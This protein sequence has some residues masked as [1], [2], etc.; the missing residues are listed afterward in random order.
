MRARGKRSAAPGSI[1]KRARVLKGRQT[2]V[3]PLSGR[4][5]FNQA[6][7]GL[8]FACPWLISGIPSG[9]WVITLGGLVM[10]RR[11]ALLS[12]LLALSIARAQTPTQTPPPQTPPSQ[13]PPSQ[14]L[15][16]PVD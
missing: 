12:L 16:P 4:K 3:A 13:S 11:V 14:I 6:F 1:V 8:R 10:S 5:F 7:Q 15:L 2:R 9:C